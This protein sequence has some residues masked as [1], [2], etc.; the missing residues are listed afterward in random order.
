MYIRNMGIL[1]KMWAKKF[2]I[3]NKHRLS[4]YSLILMLLYYL[5]VT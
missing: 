2:Q 3:I 5:I 1:I 4:S